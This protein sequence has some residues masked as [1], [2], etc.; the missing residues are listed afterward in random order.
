MSIRHKKNCW[1]GITH[2][3]L[4]KICLTLNFQGRLW[5][6]LLE[7]GISVLNFSRNMPDV[8]FSHDMT[9]FWHTCIC[10]V[11]LKRSTLLCGIKLD[12]CF[13][14][15]WL[16]IVHKHKYLLQCTKTNTNTDYT[17]TVHT[18]TKKSAPPYCQSLC[19][20]KPTINL[21]FGLICCVTRNCFFFFFFLITC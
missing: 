9:S 2:P 1:F 6:F 16:N 12:Y 15:I 18:H 19:Y 11:W 20:A 3:T 13:Y 4:A 7:Q 17:N 8:T 5:W 14:F 21:F 10:T